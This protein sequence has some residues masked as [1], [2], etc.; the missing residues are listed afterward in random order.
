MKIDQNNGFVNRRNLGSRCVLELGIIYLIIEIPDH[1][2][3]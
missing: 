2:T 3:F 1:A